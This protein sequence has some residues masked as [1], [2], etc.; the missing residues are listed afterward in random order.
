MTRRGRFTHRAQ[1]L[2]PPFA[3]PAA[4]HLSL[5]FCADGN[6]TVML[7]AEVSELGVFDCLVLET[8][9]PELAVSGA[10]YMFLIEL[11]EAMHSTGQA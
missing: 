2:V 7:G 5:L 9:T 6:A 1:R 10:G 11:K 3:I 8:D 4:A